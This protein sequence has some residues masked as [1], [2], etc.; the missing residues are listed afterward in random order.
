MLFVWIISAFWEDIVLV[1]MDGDKGNNGLGGF[2]EGELFKELLTVVNLILEIDVLE[3]DAIEV[4]FD[5][6]VIE[7]SLEEE[8]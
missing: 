5:D 6:D 7:I 3:E 2:L 8:L 1:L 4:L